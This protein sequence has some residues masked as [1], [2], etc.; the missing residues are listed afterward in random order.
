MA[1][2]P[3]IR[4]SF[5]SIRAAHEAQVIPPIAS[6]TAAVPASEPAAVVAVVAECTD[7]GSSLKP[8]GYP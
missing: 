4:L 5:F 8:S 1:S 3:S 2:T 6:S 7:T